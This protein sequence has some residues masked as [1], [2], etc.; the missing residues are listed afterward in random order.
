MFSRERRIFLETSLAASAVALLHLTGA[1]KLLADVPLPKEATFTTQV[2][3][4]HE[5]DYLLFKQ[6]LLGQ[7]NK[8]MQPVSLDTFIRGLNGQIEIPSNAFM[9]TADDSR[10]SQFT[11]G[12]R[13][14]LEIQKETGI[15]IPMVIFA[16]TKFGDTTQ[17]FDQE[18]DEAVSFSDASSNSKGHDCMTKG[19]LK[20][21]IAEG[22]SVQNHTTNHIDMPNVSEDKRNGDVKTCEDRLTELYKEVGVI[23]KYKALA[24]PFGHYQGQID[25]VQ[26]Q[27]FDVAFSTRNTKLQTSTDRFICGRVGL[28]Y[29]V[30]G[31][32]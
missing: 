20:I 26:S 10:K 25:Y 27:G 12:R 3:Y 2:P 18:A 14:I 7:F 21:L 15:F 28:P 16:I 11:N 17:P 29:S 4:A 23:R 9:I 24:Y 8:G 6:Y 32:V 19:D 5:I 31:Q 30:N 13:A 22:H 1:S